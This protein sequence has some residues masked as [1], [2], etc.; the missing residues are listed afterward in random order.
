LAIVTPLGPLADNSDTP[1]SP[2]H[3]V[4]SPSS[5]SDVLVA[6]AELDPDAPCLLTLPD[7]P[8]GELVARSYAE[9][10]MRADRLRAALERHGVVRGEPVGC[11][12]A[13]SPAW[14][15]SS[16]AV[17]HSGAVV[18]AV[19]TLLPPV[20][21][22]RLF[23]LASVRVVIR[24]Q[25]SGSLEGFEEIVI[26]AEGVV[27]NEESLPSP[28]GRTL[29]EPSE[30]AC[31]FFTSGTTGRPKGITHTHRDFVDGARK[32]ASAYA[33]SD[34]YRPRTA[35]ATLAPGVV[36]N[37]FGHTAGYGRFGFRL[38]IGRPSIL[39]TK[40]SIPA[41]RTL[42]DRFSFD[43]LQLSPAM[44]YM[45]AT[46]DEPLSLDSIAY[47]TSGTAPLAIATRER[48]EERYHVPVMQAY[49]MTEA[50]SIATERFDD[51]KEGRRG[52]GSV[53]RLS[54]GV[55]VVIRDRESG[56]VC[57][58]GEDGEIFVRTT[59]MPTEFVG[60]APVPVDEE[61]WFATGDVGHFD[62]HEILY[63]TGRAQEKLI[64]GGFNVYPAEV[65]DTVRQSD[66]VLD[67]V[68]VGLPDERLG[69]LP[70]VGVVWSG[71]PD[72]DR[73]LGDVRE[74]LA[75]YKVPRFAFRLNEIPLTPREKV[76][77]PRAVALALE[78]LQARDAP[79]SLG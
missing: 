6:R 50:G 43:S 20:E 26:D 15:V 65:E 70:V 7:T 44:V 57:N 72:E 64:V 47:V 55:E 73:L 35:P 10:L 23:E 76:D 42:L 31:I 3:G 5:L 37:P 74:R 59:E 33:K 54:K 38:W 48:F 68:V 14:V 17:W 51:V 53:G 21:A 28:G 29:P 27:T 66:G 39:V 46:T 71:E 32:V 79:E 75:H 69:E 12:L 22:A 49:G 1:V 62:E 19:G 67:A 60:G 30:V 13:N 61:G 16:F 41:V 9:I 36:F 78:A 24:A 8:E 56:A 45:L 11:Y 2:L 25:E 4:E 18:A 58:S 52:P 77:R 34:A 63:I 40:F